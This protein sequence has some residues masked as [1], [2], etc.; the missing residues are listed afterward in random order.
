[1]NFEQTKELLLHNAEMNNIKRN[2]PWGFEDDIGRLQTAISC[3]KEAGL[4][5]EFVDDGSGKEY[6]E[7]Q[8]KKA[9]KYRRQAIDE[10]NQAM[11]HIDELV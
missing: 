7:G 9:E 6:T 2:M 3:L 1:M 11:Q 10:I 8:Y 4:K 5:S